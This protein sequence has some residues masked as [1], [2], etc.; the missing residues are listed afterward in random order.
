MRE[1]LVATGHGTPEQLT[2]WVASRVQYVY[3]TGR[4]K[5]ASAAGLNYD[6]GVADRDVMCG[7]PELYD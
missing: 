5:P 1:Y 3:H 7:P 6:R 2:Q 4:E